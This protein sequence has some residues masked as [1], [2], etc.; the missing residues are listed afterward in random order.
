MF[1][2]SKLFLILGCLLGLIALGGCQAII[3]DENDSQLPQ[4]EPASWEGTIPG[5]PTR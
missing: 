5:M 1:R 2:I 3:G 4:S